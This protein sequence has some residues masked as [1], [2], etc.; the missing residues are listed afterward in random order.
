MYLSNILQ[1]NFVIHCQQDLRC[2]RS[3]LSLIQGLGLVLCHGASSVKFALSPAWPIV[4]SCKRSYACSRQCRKMANACNGQAIMV[5]LLFD[6]TLVPESSNRFPNYTPIQHS[7]SSKAGS[8]CRQGLHHN[9]S[10]LL[11]TDHHTLGDA[12]HRPPKRGES[13]NILFMR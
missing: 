11:Y 10:A 13:R 2:I 9:Q 8:W 5:V 6:N 3:H 4:W 12:R 7:L 1:I